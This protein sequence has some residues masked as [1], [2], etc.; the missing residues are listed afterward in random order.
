MFLE[1]RADRDE[2]EFS[3]FMT[4]ILPTAEQFTDE[5]VSALLDNCLQRRVKGIVIL[6]NEML[7]LI[8]NSSCKVTDQE[9]VIVS[10]FTMLL[11]L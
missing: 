5:R 2:I 8:A 11:Q 4:R 7:G 3:L 1:F 9:A 6:L 10:N